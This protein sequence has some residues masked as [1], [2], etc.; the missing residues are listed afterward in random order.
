MPVGTSAR[1]RAWNPRGPVRP[2]LSPSEHEAWRRFIHRRCG[3]AFGETR[4]A[5]LARRLWRRMVPTGCKSYDGYLSQVRREPREWLELLEL[6]T[7]GETSFF[8][9][10]PS[11]EAL[12][13]LQARLLMQQPSPRRLSFWSAGCSTGQE[14]Y[15][16]ALTALHGI[17]MTGIA[18][19]LRV[20]AGDVSREARKRTREGCYTARQ[21]ASVPEP[22]KRLYFERQQHAGG[23]LY[24]AGKALRE[25]VQPIPWNLSVPESY[26]QE[27]QDIIFCQNLLIYLP[28]E[29]RGTVVRRLG[30][31]LRPGGHLVL[32]PGELL[33]PAPQGL[34][35]VPLPDCQIYRRKPSPE[36]PSHGPR[37]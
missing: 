27:P 19:D 25:V 17:A 8:R 35:S 7:N 2:A 4:G 16:M 33:E 9:H 15:S 31:C 10:P 36:D 23:T 26:P 18:C 3:L 5:F 29:D 28:A 22:L 30:N 20:L 11:F 34:Y 6:L 1:A 24:R 21:I 32:A 12:A 13:E 37:D 14:P